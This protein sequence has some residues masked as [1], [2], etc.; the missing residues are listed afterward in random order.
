M[1]PADWLD[2]WRNAS[3]FRILKHAVKITEIQPIQESVNGVTTT[4]QSQ[5]I[6]NPS[7]WIY[8][9][10]NRL[11][12]LRGIRPTEV[13]G[14][15][16]DVNENMHVPMPTSQQMGMLKRCQVDLGNDSTH[17][18]ID[19]ANQPLGTLITEVNGMLEI[20]KIKA[21]QSF[22]YDSTYDSAKC[23]WYP[24]GRFNTTELKDV[25]FA[26]RFMP[27]QAPTTTGSIDANY[28]TLVNHNFLD[29]TKPLM[30]KIEDYHSEQ[31]SIKIIAKIKVTYSC[32]I[33]YQTKIDCG[34]NA[35]QIQ[36]QAEQ[37]SQTETNWHAS[38][39]PEEYFNFNRPRLL[40]MY[41]VGL[42]YNHSEQ[43]LQVE[44]NPQRMEPPRLPQVNIAESLSSQLAQYFDP[45]TT[46]ATNNA[47]I[48]T[49]IHDPAT[50]TPKKI[51]FRYKRKSQ[52]PKPTPTGAKRL[53]TKSYGDSSILV[54]ST[55]TP[56]FP[57]YYRVNTDTGTI[58]ADTDLDETTT[59]QVIRGQQNARDQNKDNDPLDDPSGLW[60]PRT[61]Y[62]ASDSE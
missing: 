21:G 18:I 10:P 35:L 53:R 49:T 5:F 47:Q 33:E 28:A 58:A 14:S 51:P 15:L 31:G 20:S 60:K 41:G 43:T 45:D 29:E 8:R 57:N 30:I 38:A 52:P 40:T 1:R 12:G 22:S 54:D 24:L 59:T 26:N 25:A 19:T 37:L 6:N 39:V 7:L 23:R 13:N 2:G 50:S 36:G 11:F 4:V 34:F 44:D 56:I 42:S 16:Y 27:R 32:E 46:P 61:I 62:G 17:S 3:A 9:D 55:G 48:E